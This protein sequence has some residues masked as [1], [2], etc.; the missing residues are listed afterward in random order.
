MPENWCFRSM[1]NP[2]VAHL[3]PWSHEFPHHD[4]LVLWPAL[5]SPWCFMRWQKLRTGNTGPVWTWSLTGIESWLNLNPW[6]N[7]GVLSTH[8]FSHINERWWSPLLFLSLENHPFTCELGEHTGSCSNFIRA[9]RFCFNPGLFSQSAVW[10][11]LTVCRESLEE[12]PCWGSICI[13]AFWVFPVLC[14]QWCE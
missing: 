8:H 2:H 11:S 1:S 10:I 4:P 12:E 14:V 13:G 6:L 7:L 5:S 9:N 3:L